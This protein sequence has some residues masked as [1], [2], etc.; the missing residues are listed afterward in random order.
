MSLYGGQVT[1]F[2]GGQSGNTSP[3]EAGHVQRKVATN[4]Q[5][6]FLAGQVT[7]WF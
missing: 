3:G 7:K 4:K 1:L 2:Q 5:L 6:N